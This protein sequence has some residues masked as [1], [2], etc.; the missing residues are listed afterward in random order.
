MDYTDIFVAIILGVAGFMDVKTKKVSNAWILMWGLY[1]VYIKGYHFILAFL[2]GI[3]CLYIFYRLH[4]FGAGDVKLVALLGAYLGL[5]EALVISFTGLVFAAVYA[6]YYLLRQG[7]LADRI[8][9][10]IRFTDMSLKHGR[11]YKYNGGLENSMTMPMAPYFLA[12]FIVWRVYRI[13]MA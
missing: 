13:W 10:F 9:Y 5:K 1:G 2:L 8:L 6:L 12:A 7:A 11:L 4:F 3:V